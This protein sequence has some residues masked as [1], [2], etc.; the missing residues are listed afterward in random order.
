MRPFLTYISSPFRHRPRAPIHRA[1]GLRVPLPAAAHV[2][3]SQLARARS[4]DRAPKRPEAALVTPRYS[5]ALGGGHTVVR[6][7]KLHSSL[8]IY[9]YAYT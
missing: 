2:A 9:I 1:P 3:G 4:H 6:G 8:Y 7:A 5:I